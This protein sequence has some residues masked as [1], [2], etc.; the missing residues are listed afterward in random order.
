MGGATRRL[1][2]GQVLIFD[3]RTT[4]REFLQQLAVLL[5]GLGAS[6]GLSIVRGSEVFAADVQLKSDVKLLPWTGDDFTFG[7][8]LRNSEIPKFPTASER[9]IDFVIVGGGM[10]AL[11]AA[12]HL[13]DH[14]YLLLE[15]YQQT[16]GN[17]RGSNSRGLWYSYGSQYLT[18]ID[19]DVG[20]IISD[21]RLKPVKVGTEKNAWW[22]GAHFLK[23]IDGGTNAI[24]KDFKRLRSDMKSVW[25]KMGNATMYVSE[26][27]PELEKLD[28]VLLSTMLTGYSAPF[29][30]LIEGFMKS[31]ACGGANNLSAL[32]GLS[33]LE[34]LV[35]PSYLLEGGNPALTRAIANSIKQ[36]TPQRMVTD[37]FVW[38]VTLKDDGA[39]VV[40]QDKGGNLHR[41]NCKHAI[42]AV[43]PMIAT[44]LVNLKVPEK[45]QMYAI[46]YGSYLVGN[47]I[48]NK[49]VFNSSFDNWL[50]SKYSFPDI[51]IANTA[52]DLNGH[53]RKE[54]G[55]VLTVYQPYLAGSEGRS[56]LLEG[57]R[58]KF[59]LQLRKQLAGILGKD[60]DASLE[61][62][63][64]SRWGHAMA[65][66]GPDYFKRMK[67][68]LAAQTNSYSFA[69]SS[70][71]GLPAAESAIRGGRVAAQRA[72]KIKKTKAQFF[73]PMPKLC[74]PSTPTT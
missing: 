65:V 2:K 73:G 53:Y 50:P 69:H 18:E 41:V 43:S 66:T 42:I 48:L 44:R 45:A 46:R 9:N 35:I 57:D 39:S 47:F 61:T 56:L 17:A 10:A 12:H 1:A 68:I 20:Q 38:N 21:M 54:M 33:V 31:S 51:T 5:C 8:R 64:L 24:Y 52:Y 28:K 7:H 55:Q 19:G 4:R 26:L 25:S 6:G 74:A 60:F 29:M 15:Q 23:G 72:L 40:Y 22:D 37:A 36:K 59:S 62:V 58:D 63:Q 14:D 71:H 70:Y 27:T 13:K 32:A 67:K 3:E 49:K 11:T 34:D 30:D 16:G